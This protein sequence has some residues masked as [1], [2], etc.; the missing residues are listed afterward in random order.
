L[1]AEVIDAAFK[2]LADPL[3]DPDGGQVRRV[4]EAHHMSPLP[5]EEGVG[6]CRPRAFGRVA[7]APSVSR[8]MPGELEAGPGRRFPKADDAEE[9]PGRFLFRHPRA[10]SFELPV[11]HREGHV[12]PGPAAIPG[13][14]VADKAHDLRV[15]VEGGV[16]LEVAALEPSQ[17]QTRGLQGRDLGSV[18]GL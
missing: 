4:H 3:G 10:E 18:H 7:L 12:P 9:G 17:A 11:A 13:R 1:P 14:A 15:S 16:V 8:E 6:E 2:T 5:D